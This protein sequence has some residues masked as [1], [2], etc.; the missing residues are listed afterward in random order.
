MTQR[1]GQHENHQTLLATV[2]KLL[3]LVPIIVV[4]E[5]NGNIHMKKTFRNA[6]HLEFVNFS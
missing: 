6:K 4:I 1:N 5:R 3:V 2:W